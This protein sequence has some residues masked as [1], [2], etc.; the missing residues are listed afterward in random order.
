MSTSTRSS[1]SD[2]FS[3]ADIAAIILAPQ[4]PMFANMNPFF[5][6]RLQHI[7][8]REVECRSPDMAKQNR[9][10]ADGSKPNPGGDSALTQGTGRW[11]FELG[12]LFNQG[13][14]QEFGEPFVRFYREVSSRLIRSGYAQEHS[15][16]LNDL[17]FK[18][19]PGTPE[20]ISAAA[21]LGLLD[22]QRNAAAAP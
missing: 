19:Q 9:E 13:F 16:D 2:P 20:E 8:V 10:M 21:I 18:T 17:L 3:A 7:A 14:R 15:V 22:Q 1:G 11:A 5:E 12:Q 6:A 4:V